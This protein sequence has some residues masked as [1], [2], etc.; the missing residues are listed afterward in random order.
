MALELDRGSTRLI[1]VNMVKTCASPML[2]AAHSE[3]F[4]IGNEIDPDIPL[5]IFR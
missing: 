4:N 1:Q 3:V 2:A 5:M